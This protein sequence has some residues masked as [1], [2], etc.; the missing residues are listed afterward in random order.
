M[1]MDRSARQA[2]G[3][4]RQPWPPLALAACTAALALSVV[5][6]DALRGL[7][8]GGVDIPLMAVPFAMAGLAIL[9]WRIVRSTT[10]AI[11]WVLLAIAVSANLSLFGEAYVQFAVAQDGAPIAIVLWLTDAI[12]LPVTAQF[13]SLLLLLFPTGRLPSPRWR[14]AAWTWA[15]GLAVFLVWATIDPTAY[16]DRDIGTFANPLAP[17]VPAA[18][19]DAL[20][21]AAAALSFMAAIAAV[22]SL[23][24][25]FRRSRGEERTQMKWLVLVATTA[26]ALLVF[27]LVV[28]LIPGGRRGG[29]LLVAT[30]VAW[31]VFFLL[32]LIGIPGVI[33]VAVLRYRL[34]DVDLI[35]RKTVVAGALVLFVAAVYVAAVLVVQ[36]FT[37]D[38]GATVAFIAGL[39]V[40]LA[41]GPVRR[42]A[43]RLADR[44]V[45]GA[46]A[47]P[48]EVL[49]ALSERVGETYSVEDI[50]PRLAT[51]L[52]EATGAERTRVWIRVGRELVPA[53]TWPPDAAI[54]GRMPMNGEEIPPFAD[55]S[56]FPVRHLGEL[57][58]AI[59]VGFP[60]A[61]PITPPK[62][63]LVT[64]LAAQVGLVLRNARLIEELRSSRQRLVAAQDEERRRIERNIHDGAQQ[65]LVALAV[66]LR[67]LEQLAHRDA[68]RTA[69][70]AAQLQREAGEALDDLRDLARGIFPPL[71]S[72]RGLGA[73]LEAQARKSA[74]PVTVTIE[75][76]G[77]FPQEIESTVY[78]CCLE[79]MQNAAKYS[80]ASL[81]D[82]RLATSDDELTFEVTDDGRG[83][84]PQTRPAGSG[85]QGM[86]DRLDAIGGTL[87][88]WSEP[89]RGTRIMG[90]VRIPVPSEHGDVVSLS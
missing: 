40:A 24:V 86:A 1:T 35:V 71:L 73:A 37:T 69:D 32:V 27:M 29:A 85:L 38:Q 7:T 74:L 88:V 59:T 8:V 49:T 46:R 55:E 23:I 11:G 20:A 87:E 53:A 56:A 2:E 90:R 64:D 16:E 26:A 6:L 42:L 44:L 15:L 14:A 60:R 48:Y 3:N 84:E 78:F 77:R 83:F 9:G 34:Y 76:L 18:V 81:V 21:T 65:Q 31:V 68:V 10:N 12:A 79:A 61:D 50:L 80:Q 30:D 62:A 58:G 28:D 17:D 57:L 33:A 43:R 47:T 67:L 22:A 13:I 89:G 52:A 5:I 25:R 51:T 41:F 36:R 45:Y 72:D 4:L 70:L 82:V 54:V 66:K 75:A 39:L 19:R 63:Q